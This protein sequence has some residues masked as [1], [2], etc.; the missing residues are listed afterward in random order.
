M[1][2]SHLVPP[3]GQRRRGADSHAS[4]EMIELEFQIDDGVLEEDIRVDLPTANSAALQETYFTMPVRLAIDGVELLD[5]PGITTRPWLP[6]PLL[7]VALVAVDR[8]AGL[9]DGTTATYSLPGGGWS[10][11]LTRTGAAVGIESTIN[12]KSASSAFLDLRS[13]G[14]MFRERVRGMLW[15]RLP[16]LRSHPLWGPWLQLPNT[17]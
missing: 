8:I 2:W 12:G 3:L 4:R 6:L 16:Q 14:L 5:S 17:R 1:D 9:R 15:T 7:D 13:A 11:V 10:L